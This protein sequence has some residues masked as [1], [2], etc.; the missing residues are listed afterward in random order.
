VPCKLDFLSIFSISGV[1][2]LDSAYYDIFK[3]LS[4]YNLTLYNVKNNQKH[5]E[6]TEKNPI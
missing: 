4:I 3:M 6:M 2:L 1:F 5:K